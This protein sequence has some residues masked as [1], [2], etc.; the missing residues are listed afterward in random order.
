MPVCQ[1]QHVP[2]H[3]FS[4][5]GIIR[6]V[7]AIGEARFALPN[8]LPERI[9][10]ELGDAIHVKDLALSDA[11]TLLPPVSF[12]FL[13]LHLHHNIV[14]VFAIIGNIIKTQP[15]IKVD[16]PALEFSIGLKAHF[17]IAFG[18]RKCKK[19]LHHTI[20]IALAL[21]FHTEPQAF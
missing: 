6:Y 16:C 12:C 13:Q 18:T 2:R 1:F 8:D 4:A 19:F 10:V 17:F 14:G 20:A 11:V 21:V 9:E 15:V 5:G 3:G 7:W